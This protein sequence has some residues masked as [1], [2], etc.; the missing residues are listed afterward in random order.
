MV[1]NGPQPLHQKDQIARIA[2]HFAHPG[3]AGAARGDE[4]TGFQ[5]VAIAKSCT[6]AGPIPT[7]WS[8]GNKIVFQNREGGRGVP[9]RRAPA[10]PGQ[11]SSDD[12]ICVMF[13]VHPLDVGTLSFESRG[14]AKFFPP[15][16]LRA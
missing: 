2:A 3:A 4:E 13:R 15:P 9:T 6:G 8:F 7:I 10:R 16:L 5:G 11:G 14:G 1:M 12:L